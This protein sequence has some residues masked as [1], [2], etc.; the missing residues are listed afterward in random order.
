M[1]ESPAF[2]EKPRRSLWLFG[3]ESEQPTFQQRRDR[4]AELSVELG[5]EITAPQ[6][7]DAEELDLPNPR[8]TPPESLASFCFQD[9]YER[10]LHSASGNRGN[11]VYL[12]VPNPPDVVAHPVM[13]WSWRLF[14]SGVMT[15]D[16]LPSPMVEARQWWME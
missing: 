2:K 1:N 9:N 5:T 14:S 8:I 3:L 11:Y 7:P 15:A 12:G 4:A 16:S 6:I 10:A 13:T